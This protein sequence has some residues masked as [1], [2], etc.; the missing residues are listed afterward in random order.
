MGDHLRKRRLDLGLLQRE[1]AEQIG[2]DAMTI[3]N[4]E[5]QRTVPEIRCMPRIIEF[6]GYCPLAPVRSFQERLITYRTGLGLSQR[7]MARKLG[8]DQ[9]TLAGWESGRHRPTEESFRIVEAFFSNL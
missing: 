6:L 3:C 4:W 8:V 9:S 7:K 5:K 1:I 2:V